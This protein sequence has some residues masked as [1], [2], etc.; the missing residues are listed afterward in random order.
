MSEH[1]KI[2]ITIDVED[3]FQV[4]NL[5]S[6]YDHSKWDSVESHVEKNTMRVLELLDT[7][8]I[9]ATFFVLGWIAERYPKLVRSI[10]DAGHEVASH[11]YS[12]VLNY[13]LSEKDL[14]EDL[15]RV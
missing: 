13:H 14:K 4:E 3:W 11:G 2:A 15:E 9:K 5:R 1:A 6:V 8:K 7:S 10:S 12:H